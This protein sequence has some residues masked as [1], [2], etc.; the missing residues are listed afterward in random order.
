MLS[1]MSDKGTGM[2]VMD[3]VKNVNTVCIVYAFLAF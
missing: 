1:A 2:F 3:D